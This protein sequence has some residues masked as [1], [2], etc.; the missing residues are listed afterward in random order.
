[1][2]NG[3]V[4]VGKSQWEDML[5]SMTQ[6]VTFN[7]R[8]PATHHP[9]C[10]GWN[11]P[12]MLGNFRTCR[13]KI[14]VGDEAHVDN[15]Y[16]GVVRRPVTKSGRMRCICATKH[17]LIE[18]YPAFPPQVTDYSMPQRLV[19]VVPNGDNVSHNVRK[20]CSLAPSIINR[21]IPKIERHYE[22]CGSW[23]KKERAGRL[24]GTRVH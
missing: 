4:S 19:H 23:F 13:G 24:H 3:T 5:V 20:Y 7:A 2:S 15:H 14:L 16:S 8:V 12:C 11:S 18:N 17:A 21:N 6:S 22:K 10:H 1:M 9:T